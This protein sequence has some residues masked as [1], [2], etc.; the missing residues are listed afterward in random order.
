MKK[1]LAI[2]LTVSL[3][4]VPLNSY[5][6]TQTEAFQNQ[7][8]EQ[9]ITEGS[10]AVKDTSTVA[11]N[12]HFDE[13]SSTLVRGW[14]WRSDIPNTSLTVDIYYKSDAM[15]QASKIRTSA[16][17]YR[18][19]LANAGYGNGYHGFQCTVDWTNKAPGTYVFNVFALGGN[20]I[21]PQIAGSPK[22]IAIRPSTGNVDEVSTSQ[23]RGWVWKPDA[24]NSSIEAHIYIRRLNGEVVG[25][26]VAKAN[27]YRGDLA[28]AGYGNGNHGFS[29]SINWAN[30]PEERLSVEVYSVDNSGTNPSIYR[31][32][33]D[34]RKPIYL[35]GETD[36]EG[37]DFSYWMTST[38]R[39]YCYDIGCSDLNKWVG[40]NN[41][42]AMSAIA[43][44]SFCVIDSHGLPTSFECNYQG[45]FS[46]VISNMI[47][48]DT[49]RDYSTTRCV[50]LLT[51]LNGYERE[52]GRYN[53]VNTLQRKGV[54]TVVGF[55]T[56]IGY[57][58]IPGTLNVDPEKGYCFWAR[59][60]IKELRLN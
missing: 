51:C 36:K 9:V 13:L 8:V 53:M 46:N 18:A 50:L 14:A 54:W 47:E 43:N 40:F 21:N 57:D 27:Q 56:S 45:E 3:I 33:Y 7:A 22:Y 6:Q 48:E 12:G 44:S 17:L 52:N 30:L 60:F 25:G 4:L 59:E 31:G 24:P 37:V 29:Y 5:A 49:T 58:L 16:N 11:P 19:D 26:Y 15:A 42:A 23:I 55:E 38:V 28:N 39:N 10:I 34:N 2:L 32:Y 1:F 20:D 41:Y 35:L